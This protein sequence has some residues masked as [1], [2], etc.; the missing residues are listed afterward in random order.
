MGATSSQPS[1]GAPVAT[2][3]AVTAASRPSGKV[4]RV[5]PAWKLGSRPTTASPARTRQGTLE[6]VPPSGDG[7]SDLAS[8]GPE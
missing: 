4:S 8:S 1:P 7:A 3:Q 5:R 6:R 2:S